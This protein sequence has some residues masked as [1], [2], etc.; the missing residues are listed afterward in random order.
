MICAAWPVEFDSPLTPV[1]KSF[2]DAWIAKYGKWEG[3]EIQGVGQFTILTEALKQAGSL[4]TDKV[5]AVISNGLKFE[6][7][8]GLAM[9]IDRPDMG[10]SRTIDSVN[11]VYMKEIKKGQPSLLATISLDEALTYFRKANSP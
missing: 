2:K 1:A 3:P 4:D 6:G 5:S 11:T 10:N 7:P 9:M 8:N